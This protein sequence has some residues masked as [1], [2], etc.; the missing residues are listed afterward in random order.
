MTDQTRIWLEV[1]HHAAFRVAGWGLVRLDAAGVSGFAGGE[2]QADAERSGLAG[3]A[4]A[5][6]DLP[7]GARVELNT[8]SRDLLSIPQR[9]ADA[10][11]GANPPTDNLDLWAQVTSALARLSVRFRASEAAPKS[12]TAFAAAWADLGRDR[13]KDRGPF[14]SAIPRSNLAKAGL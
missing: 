3:L 2:R 7:P 4:A 12:P 10:A 6:A 9:I 13:A 14:R 11:S 5:L 1:A 8:S